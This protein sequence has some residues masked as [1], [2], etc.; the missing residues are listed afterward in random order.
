MSSLDVEELLL[1]FE[2]SF[3]FFYSFS[4]LECCSISFAEPLGG[5]LGLLAVRQ[6][7]NSCMCPAFVVP[8]HERRKI[9]AV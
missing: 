4:P 3:L 7:Y 1:M 8:L 5:D 9:Y 6:K 2:L